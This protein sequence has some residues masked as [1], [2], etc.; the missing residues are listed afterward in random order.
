[1]TILGSCVS[2]TMFSKKAGI[3]GIC[4][5]LLPLRPSSAPDSEES[6]YVDSSIAR[7]LK[8]FRSRGISLNA[9]EIKVFGGADVLPASAGKTVGRANIEAAFRTLENHGFRTVVSDV[10]GTVGR[11]IVFSTGEGSVRVKK[12][13]DRLHYQ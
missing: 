10:G 4:H 8:E 3:G 7:M 13:N 5:A 12:L 9:M 6:R 11:K 1:M 2:V